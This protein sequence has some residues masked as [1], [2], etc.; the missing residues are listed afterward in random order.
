[1]REDRSRRTRPEADPGAA[2]ADE[3]LAPLRRETV[4]L[5]VAGP[6]MARVRAAGSV[7]PVPARRAELVWALSLGLAA[8][9][10]LIGMLVRL[11]GGLEGAYAGVR[12]LAN[13]ARHFGSRFAAEIL[14]LATQ[15][16]TAA[17]PM[18]RAFGAVLAAA[19]P[20]VRGA[21]LV[22]AATGALSIVVSLYV[23]A[24]ARDAAPASGVRHG[25]LPHG[26]AR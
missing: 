12:S 19:A 11:S 26:G 21:G 13:P 3:V 14:A 2:W 4:C 8:V 24:H 6:V 25:T 1:M 15:A 22:A 18:L 7:S 9:S 5:D 10:F 17:A 20:L 23:F 16:A